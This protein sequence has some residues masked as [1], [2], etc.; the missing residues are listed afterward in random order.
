MVLPQTVSW[1]VQGD[2]AGQKH[3][4]VEDDIHRSSTPPVA[5]ASDR[6]KPG[7]RRSLWRLVYH[8]LCGW[9]VP[10]DGTCSL[11]GLD[12]TAVLLYLHATLRRP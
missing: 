10:A 11:V 4:S 5:F 7:I 2:A 9:L 1:S 8:E 6:I 12:D 3:A